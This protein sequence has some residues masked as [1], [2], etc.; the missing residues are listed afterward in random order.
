MEHTLGKPCPI[1]G[2]GVVKE[3]FTDHSRN[4]IFNSCKHCHSDKRTIGQ[5]LHDI[6]KQRGGK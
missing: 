1:S 5:R 6:N 4:G 3:S 2:R